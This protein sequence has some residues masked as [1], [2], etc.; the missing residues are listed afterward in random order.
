MRNFC[1]A[2]LVPILAV[3]LLVTPAIAAPAGTPAAPLGMIVDASNAHAGADLTNAGATVYDGDHLATRDDATMRL[4]LGTGQ[5]YLHNAT[6]VD[7]HALPNGFSADVDAGTI[8]ASSPEGQ[9]FQLQVDGVIVRPA[10]PH[11]TS[12]QIVRISPTEAI[13]SST[14]GDL[15]V[16]LEDEVKTVSAGSSY[17][18][19][20]STEDE[21]SGKNQGPTPAGRNRHVFAL[22][23]IAGASAATGYLIY[24]AV[25]SPTA[26]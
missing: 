24:R 2:C 6:A 20:I 7:V 4:R 10:T 25:I 3:A 23:L 21:S 13:L 11:A 16:T 18:L 15:L 22:L 14:R 1:H 26:P 5:L 12:A 19:E 17:K 9:T 8:S